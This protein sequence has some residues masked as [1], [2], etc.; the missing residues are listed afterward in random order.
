AVDDE[1][2]TLELVRV[3]LER[4]GAVVTTATDAAAALDALRRT[5][6][7]VLLTDIGMPVE[8]GY[9]LLRRVRALGA[10]EG[11]QT[12]AIALTAY[13][14]DADRSRTLAAGFQLHLPKPVDAAQLVAVIAN[15][16][17]TGERV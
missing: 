10:D 16:A 3:I 11:G 2:D 12:P 8:D 7:D 15:L 13:A 5:R 6:P 9:H 4:A 14:G 17:G 1:R